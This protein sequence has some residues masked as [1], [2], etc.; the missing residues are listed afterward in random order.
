LTADAEL[1]ET[2]RKGLE[3]SGIEV[4]EDERAIND[5]GFARDIAEALV[6]KMGLSS[7]RRAE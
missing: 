1:F 3:G 7:Q 4:V 5:E 6:K 2:V